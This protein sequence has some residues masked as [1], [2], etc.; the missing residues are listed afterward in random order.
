[1]TLDIKARTKMSSTL[2]YC[3]IRERDDLGIG[4]LNQG[5]GGPEGM[6]DCGPGDLLPT[7]KANKRFTSDPKTNY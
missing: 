3:P 2:V 6:M 1:M 7:G 4:E 5:A